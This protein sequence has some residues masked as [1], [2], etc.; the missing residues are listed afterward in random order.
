MVSLPGLPPLEKSDF[1]SF[2]SVP[3]SNPELF[4][5]LIL[6]QFSNLDR[7]DWILVNTL[8]KIKLK[9]VNWMSKLLR[10]RTIGPTLPSAYL[11]KPVEGDRDYGLN[12]FELVGIHV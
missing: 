3:G 8:D 7:A 2:I 1:P 6:N 12:M 5:S 11:D 10:V 9:V 4:S